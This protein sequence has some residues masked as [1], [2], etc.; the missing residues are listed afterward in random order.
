MRFTKIA[1]AGAIVAS[2]LALPA[3]ADATP[4]PVAA[5]GFDEGEGTTVADGSGH[6]NHGTAAETI[7]RDG[8]FG[9]SPHFTTTANGITVPDAPSLRTGNQLTLEAWVN[10]RSQT[11][12]TG[13][14]VWKKAGTSWS[15]ALAY[16]GGQPQLRIG[17][18]IITGNGPK[19]ASDRWTH[20]AGT[21]DGTTMR[22][23]T[24]GVQVGARENPVVVS[25]DASPLLVYPYPAQATNPPDSHID[26]VRVYGTALDA[27]QISANMATSVNGHTAPDAPP[28]PIGGL[29]ATGEYIPSGGSTGNIRLTWDASPDDRGIHG[30][31]IYRGGSPGF[32]L[33][34]LLP[35]ATA[36]TNAFT[37]PNR[38]SFPSY[39]RV[40]PID[41]SGQAG[42]VSAEVSGRPR[43]PR[44]VAVAAWGM[45]A[46][47]THVPDSSGRGHTGVGHF[48]TS[49]EGR[50]GDGLSFDGFR[51]QVEVPSSEA[52][53][54]GYQLTI[55]AW[56]K[57]ASYGR[58]NFKD[59]VVARDSSAGGRFDYV[60]YASMQPS[61]D[62]IP[63][64]MSCTSPTFC[65]G[66]GGPALPLGEWS[67]LAYTFGPEGGRLYVNG[68]RTGSH[69]DGAGGYL[70]YGSG[71]LRIGGSAADEFFHGVI[72]EVRVYDKALTPDQIVEDMNTPIV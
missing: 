13:M 15:Y 66:A 64:G 2:L 35:I 71:K 21:Y 55:E 69:S 27:A 56:V 20:I 68:V 65:T 34:N 61:F 36:T 32:S 54:V 72:D 50:H 19:F 40:V 47:D 22:V 1:V 63:L 52:L 38:P 44:P 43:P 17:A 37:D 46:G 24:N 16:S 67:H 28:G 10:P 18:A 25:Y 29:T 23:F 33:Q 49:T 57:P 51:S 11:S 39:Y 4:V 31:D 26:E 42:P 8:R 6:G 48:T 5:Y 7:W 14:V 62:N 45:E 30:Y 41:S 3:R 59:A 70:M 58:L 53:N 60:L 9:R 12:P